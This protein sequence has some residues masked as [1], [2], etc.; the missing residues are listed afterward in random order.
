MRRQVILRVER[1]GNYDRLQLL[2]EQEMDR[3]KGLIEG[4]NVQMYNPVGLHIK[5]PRDAAFLFVGLKFLIG[6]CCGCGGPD[7]SPATRRR[8]RS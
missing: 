7:T 8:W 4:L 6:G 1:E 3:L 2:G 5:W